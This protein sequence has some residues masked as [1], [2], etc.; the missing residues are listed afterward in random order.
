M[1]IGGG[2]LM[3]GQKFRTRLVLRLVADFFLELGVHGGNDIAAILSEFFWSELYRSPMTMGL[4]TG[5]AKA[6]GFEGGFVV[7]KLSD[8]ASVAIFNAP[9][10]T[11]E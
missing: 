8:H 3:W 1:G 9:P 2:R 6:Q 11:G 10:N 4:W 7:R 5:V